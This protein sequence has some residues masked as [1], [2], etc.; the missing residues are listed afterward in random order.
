[1]ELTANIRRAKFA[2]RYQG[3]RDFSAGLSVD[4]IVCGYL[5]SL[6]DLNGSKIGIWFSKP[7]TLC[8]YTKAGILLFILLHIDVGLGDFQRPDS[9]HAHLY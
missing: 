2:A 7:A 1:M 3:F 5:G 6:S 9:F 8:W 4:E